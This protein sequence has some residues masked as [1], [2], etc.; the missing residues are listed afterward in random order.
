MEPN[1]EEVVAGAL[2]S[3]TIPLK[4]GNLRKNL[5]PAHVDTSW[6]EKKRLQRLELVISKDIFTLITG[7]RLLPS[8]AFSRAH[9]LAARGDALSNKEYCTKS[10]DFFEAGQI[11]ATQA[12]KG[13]RGKEAAAERWN[14]AK[15]GKF[16]ELPPESIKT[17]EY[18][19]AKFGLAPK[20]LEGLDNL[21]IFG[22]TG[23]GKSR[24]VRDT[25]ATFYSKPMS[26]WWD[27]YSGEEVV[28][29]DDFDPSHGKFLGYFLKIWADRY[30]FNAEVKG[31]MLKIRPK[32][33]VVTS[34]YLLSAC[35]EDHET[36][37]A[38]TR[39]FNLIDM[40]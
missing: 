2:P 31:G 1:T 16:E 34:Q 39:R 14:L 5:F 25:F 7:R 40:N 8:G 12:E 13:R 17:Y 9:F 21:W 30:V 20:D 28:V 11:P 15:A 32:R 38:I 23:C 19:H 36:I 6:L 18:I 29:L 10:G 27:G 4:I 22:P 37:D 35:F 24:Y 3:T 26:K 33:V